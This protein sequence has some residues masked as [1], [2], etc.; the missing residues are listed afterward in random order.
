M[1]ADNPSHST[2]NPATPLMQEDIERPA[3]LYPPPSTTN[4]QHTDKSRF[5]RFWPPRSKP[6]FQGFERPSFSRI[7]TFTVLCLLA[8]P[9]FYA[10]TF[11]AKDRT[12]FTVR[13][14][15][16]IW[17]SGIGFVLGSILLAI[18]AQHAE[19]A[20]EFTLVGY[21]DLLRLYYFKQPGPP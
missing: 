10:L 7:V 15:V 8:Y 9:A 1:R 14:I 11:V 19:A 4:P 21:R 13:L 20:S 12:L 6:P 17:C 2:D 3:W 16:S 18:G 5:L